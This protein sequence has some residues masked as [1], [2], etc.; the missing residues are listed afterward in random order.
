[1]RGLL[2]VL[3]V[4][5]LCCVS[6]PT[7]AAE[8][9]EQVFTITVVNASSPA[10]LRLLHFA[11]PQLQFFFRT[12]ES[13]YSWQEA[14]DEAVQAGRRLPTIDELRAYIISNPSAFTQWNNMDRW[15]AV[16]NP[17]AANTKDFVQIGDWVHDGV[18]VYRGLSLIVQ[19]GY[20][21]W[22]D[23]YHEDFMKIYTEVLE[24]TQ[25]ETTPPDTTSPEASPETTPEASPETTPEAFPETTPEASPETTP[26]ASP[27]TTPEASPETRPKPS[28]HC[29][30]SRASP[31]SSCRR[32][33]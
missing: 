1:M 22:A 9:L 2:R 6:F 33:R 14:Y 11:G 32:R 18:P 19:R 23:G 12:D 17:A 26:E 21:W 20:P 25:T 15:T 27:E 4:C 10:R 29:R 31:A 28:S 8:S 7:S 13:P 5:V 16:V 3:A 24:T 30:A